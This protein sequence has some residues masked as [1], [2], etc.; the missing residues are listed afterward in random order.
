MF[1][2]LWFILCPSLVSIQ[3]HTK[4]K[5]SNH[6]GLEQKIGNKVEPNAVGKFSLW[7]RNEAGEQLID[8][9]E[10]NTLLQIHVSSNQIDDCTYGHHQMDNTEIK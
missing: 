2:Y 7:I 9:C 1:F 10:A 4:N 5:I 6:R 3:D 8:F